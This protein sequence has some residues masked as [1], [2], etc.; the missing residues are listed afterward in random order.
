MMAGDQPLLSIPLVRVRVTRFDLAAVVEGEGIE[1]GID[2][3]VAID[4]NRPRI[5]FADGFFL[6]EMD[7]VVLLV[8]RCHPRLVGNGRQENRLGRVVGD[9][10][11]RVASL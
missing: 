4:L 8:R 6:E 1:P 11:L 10:L 3:G 2:S 5:Y 7:K 9:D